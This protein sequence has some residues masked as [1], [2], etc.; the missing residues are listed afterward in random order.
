M[1]LFVHLLAMLRI[2]RVVAN[3]GKSIC[4]PSW[5]LSTRFH[6]KIWTA[7]VWRRLRRRRLLGCLAESRR[8][9][10]AESVL[11]ARLGTNPK[12]S[13]CWL[14]LYLAAS[15]TAGTAPHDG[16]GMI[17]F[18]AP[19]FLDFCGS[20]CCRLISSFY[21]ALCSLTHF[22]DIRH[23][24]FSLNTPF[25]RLRRAISL[26]LSLFSTH[27]GFSFSSLTDFFCW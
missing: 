21:F 26:S 15:T 14:A 7:A 1:Y 4:T 12:A 2:A 27:L 22:G 10:L 11:L 8:K 20:F 6:E 17:H 23:R 3:I 5:R 24:T 9:W 25:F 18:A 19:L 13:C 16:L